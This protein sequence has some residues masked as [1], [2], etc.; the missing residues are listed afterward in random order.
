MTITKSA[1]H[2]YLS[3]LPFAPTNSLVSACYSSS[4]PHTLHMEHGQLAH[5]PSLEIVISIGSGKNSVKSIAFSPD[6]QQIIAC[7]D[8]TI[9]LWDATT[10]DIEG[11]FIANT[12]IYSVAFSPDGQ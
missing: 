11:L 6:G 3:A 4:F 7:S 9:H 2:V 12:S 1:T 8:H 10:G 5:W